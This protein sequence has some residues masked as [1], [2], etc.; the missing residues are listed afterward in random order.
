L[1]ASYGLNEFGDNFA[2][3]ALA[4]LVFDGTGSA[5]ATAGLFVAG[6]FVPALSAPLLTA[7]VDRASYRV[8]L[9]SLYAIESSVFV[10]LAVIAATQFSLPLILALAFV[11]GTLALTARALSRAAVAAVL[12][13]ENALR[14]GNAVLNVLFAVTSALGPA[15]AGLLVAA[16][17]TAVALAIDAASFALVGLLLATASGLP[18]AGI[19][20]ADA[21]LARLRSGLTYVTQRPVI[22][23]LVSAQALAFIFFFLVIPIEVV[24]SKRTLEAGMLASGLSWRRGERAW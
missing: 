17:S 1:A 4:I 20:R 5:L 6:K 7:R 13:P 21:W 14:A 23:T 12:I 24:Y 3:V 2:I 9:P 8:V 16:T 11:D 10:L 15:V 22:R 18:P 19:E